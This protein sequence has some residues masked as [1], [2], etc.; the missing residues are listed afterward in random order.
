[1]AKGLVIAISADAGSAIGVSLHFRK[2]PF[3]MGSFGGVIFVFLFEG[4][5]IAVLDAGCLL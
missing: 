3:D 1:M 5:N 2:R 4:E